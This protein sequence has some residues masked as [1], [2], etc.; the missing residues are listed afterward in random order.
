MVF[1]KHSVRKAST[2]LRHFNN[3][4]I[5]SLDFFSILSKIPIIFIG[6]IVGSVIAIIGIFF[7]DMIGG[8]YDTIS[9]V[10]DNSFTIFF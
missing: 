2:S 9:N 5:F 10:L 4:L 1:W 8:G 7:P 3:L 6:I